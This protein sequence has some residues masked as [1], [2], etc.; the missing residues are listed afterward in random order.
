MYLTLMSTRKLT[1]KFEH[2]VC[3]IAFILIMFWVL[4]AIFVYCYVDSCTSTNSQ[5]FFYS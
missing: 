3:Y 5:S 1:E 4:L 2:D